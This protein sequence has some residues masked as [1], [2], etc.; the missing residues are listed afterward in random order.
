MDNQAARLAV[1]LLIVVG[2]GAVC[3]ASAAGMAPPRD[4]RPPT[5]PTVDQ[6]APTELRPIFRFGAT[7]DRSTRAQLRFRCA[8]DGL[9]LRPCAHI[10]RPSSALPFGPHVLRVRALDGVGNQSRTAALSFTVVGVWDAAGDF[11]RWPRQQNPGRDRYGNTTWF[12]L[13]SPPDR[14]HDPSAYVVMPT[15]W[16]VTP[17]WETWVVQPFWASATVGFNNGQI[18]LQ[19]GKIDNRQFGGFEW[20]SPVAQTVHVVAN[21]ETQPPRTCNPGEFGNGVVWWIDGGTQTLGT[22][23]LAQGAAAH[24]ELTTSVAAGDALYLIVG[25]NS[26]P[27]CDTTAVDFTVETQA[28]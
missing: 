10:Y 14:V 1:A 24:A 22:G 19:P 20:R 16:T 17:G 21:L 7:D 25:D 6:L 12:Y 9:D 4:R 23:T 13:Y 15:F 28:P 8:I 2:A 3:V 18:V 11:A 5:L 26:D 27:P